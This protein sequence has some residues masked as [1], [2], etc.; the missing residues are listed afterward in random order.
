MKLERRSKQASG[1]ALGA[2]VGG[3]LLAGAAVAAVWL[4]LGLPLPQCRFREWTGVPCPTCGSTRLVDSL[5]SGDIAAA[6]AWNPLVFVGL[7]VVILWAVAS[8]IRVT[9]GLPTWR[10]VLTRWERRVALWLA[11]ATLLA[12]WAYL[13]GRGA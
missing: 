11:G 4:R 8:A 10:L 6:A 12:S 13:I 9:F 1:Q 3:L 2:L 5:L 7:V